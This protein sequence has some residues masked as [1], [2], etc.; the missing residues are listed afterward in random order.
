MAILYCFRCDYYN[1]NTYNII[2]LPPSTHRA[3]LRYRVGVLVVL[4]PLSLNDTRTETFIF[5]LVLF[6]IFE[7]QLNSCTD[8]MYTFRF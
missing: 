1:N 7:Y 3:P 2:P 8:L 4:V 6:S 5:L